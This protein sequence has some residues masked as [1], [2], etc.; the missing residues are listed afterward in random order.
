[1][2]E[3]CADCSG[4]MRHPPD[5]L[6]LSISAV[7]WHAPVKPLAY[8]LVSI[9]GRVSYSSWGARVVVRDSR[10]LNTAAQVCTMCPEHSLCQSVLRAS[11]RPPNC[12]HM[13]LYQSQRGSP[14]AA[15]L[16][17][18]LQ[19]LQGHRECCSVGAASQGRA[20][21][22]VKRLQVKHI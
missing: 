13:C 3:C 2:S 8:V 17:G 4:T 12:V 19:S 22:T 9:T 11:M 21:H 15:G 7:C 6:P 10:V 1:M 14:A 20:R 16:H 5:A 18:H